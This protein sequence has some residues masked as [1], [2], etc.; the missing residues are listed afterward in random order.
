MIKSTKMKTLIQYGFLLFLIL[1]T[2]YIV[3]T[4]LNVKLIPE[5]I[6]MV[7]KKYIGLGFL[8]IGIYLFLESYITRIIIESIQPT[9]VKG[10]GFKMAMMGLYYNLITPLASGSQPMQIYALTKYNI[11]LSKSVAIVTNKTVIYQIVV[12]IYSGVLI[13]FNIKLLGEEMPAI[14]ILMTTG[15]V[16][17]IVSIG[18]GMLI[19]FSPNKMKKI[20][21]I[22]L[23]VLTKFRVLKFLK[24]KKEKIYYYIDEYNESVLIFIK[25]KKSLLYSFILTFVQLTLY[26]SIS[27]CVYRTFNLSQLTYIKLLTLQ[28]FL[29]I[30]VSPIPTPGNIGA[31]ELVFYTIFANVFPKE[32]I[33]YSVFLYSGFVYY[34]IAIVCGVFTVFTHYD[35]AK[36]SKTK[37]KSIF[38]K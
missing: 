5:I 21:D 16:I 29:Y 13:L 37:E 22:L 17:N 20:I 10:I 34:I 23:R 18:I 1:L 32:I 7:N 24:N 33:G 9:N 11:N 8:I 14:L 2:S 4:T 31:N 36:Y 3:S 27:Y 19:I 38:A 30:S 26:F 6:H 35:I 12:T 28:V 25:D 15:M